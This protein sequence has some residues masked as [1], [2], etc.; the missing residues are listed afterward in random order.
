MKIVIYDLEPEEIGKMNF[1][2]GEFELVSAAD[3]A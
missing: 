1:P 3:K 2:E